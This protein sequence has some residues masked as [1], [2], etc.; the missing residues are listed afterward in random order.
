[1]QSEFA[2]FLAVQCLV[3]TWLLVA[4][5]ARPSRPQRAF[6][7]IAWFA[8]F[9][10]LVFLAPQFFMPLFDYPLIGAYNILKTSQLPAVVQTQKVL[11]AFLIPVAV[12]FLLFGRRAPVRT[13]LI[14]LAATDLR[15]GIALLLIGGAAVAGMLLTMNSS[16]ARSAIVATTLGKLL[17]AVSFW[18]TLGY[19]LIAAWLIARRRYLALLLLTIIFAAALLPLGGRGRILWPLAGLVAWSAIS[20]TAR[21]RLGVLLAAAAL[22]G[23]ALQALDP[24]LLYLKGYDSKAEAIERFQA[25]LELRTFL[26]A[27]NFDAFHNL[28]V[29]VT[30]DRIPTQ[31]RYLVTGAQS[32]FM[33]TYF[34]SVAASGVGYPA[35]LPG[36][37]WLA[38]RWVVVIAGGFAFGLGLGWL[39]RIYAQLSSQRAVAVYCLAI[40]WLA[41]VGIAY[42]DSYLK[43]AALILPGIVLCHLAGKTRRPRPHAPLHVT[44]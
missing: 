27:R 35:T 33:G 21:V 26:F 28:A 42:L 11:L 24:V 20:G 3:V 1:M 34:P 37:L 23:V 12:G 16:G 43:M 13:A 8:L 32:A 7:P 41:H 5:G 22:L 31:L 17:Y 44:T 19:V 40:P 9:Y 39:S 10:L 25:G 4:A 15:R 18:F 36:G 6:S 38:G 29:V 14:P 2:V 30:E